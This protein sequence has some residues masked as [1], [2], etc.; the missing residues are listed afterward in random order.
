M[1]LE[2][3][4]KNISRHKGDIDTDMDD[5]RERIRKAEEDRMDKYYKQV[6][7]LQDWVAKNR[8]AIDDNIKMV[9]GLSVYFN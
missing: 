1:R 9:E 6:G 5:L 3:S 2:I 7:I 4:K 8:D